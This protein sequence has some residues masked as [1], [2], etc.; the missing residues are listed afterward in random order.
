MRTASFAPW[1]FSRPGPERTVAR[2]WGLYFRRANRGRC[3]RH[4]R[5]ATAETTLHRIELPRFTPIT[6][7]EI[8]RRRRLFAKV[9]TLRDEIGV[10]GVPA[11]E[12]LRESRV[13]ADAAGE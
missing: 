6:P 7:E 12:L 1:A 4:D 11:D 9:M 10:I 2:C 8:E 5:A 3:M 13:D